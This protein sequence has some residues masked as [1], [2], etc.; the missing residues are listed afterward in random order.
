[1]KTAKEM[2]ELTLN[3]WR[4]KYSHEI[5]LLEHKME[6]QAKVR[7][8]FLKVTH[9]LDPYTDLFEFVKSNK[10]YLELLGYTVNTWRNLNARG[11]YEHATIFWSNLDEE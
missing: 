4:E 10:D 2:R 9:D 3:A 6:N 8:F 7:C 5:N 11:I 1:M